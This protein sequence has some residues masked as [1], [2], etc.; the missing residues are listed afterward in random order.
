MQNLHAQGARI[1]GRLINKGTWKDRQIEYVDG[2][3][4]IKLKP[5]VQA[6]ALRAELSSLGASLAKDFDK[7]GWGLV[8]LS[9]G[10]DVFSAI[11]SLQKSALIGAVEPD[12][13]GHAGWTP[14]DPNFSP[15]QWALLNTGYYPLSRAGADIHVTQ[16]WDIT[17]GS[18]SVTIG[19]LD[20]G[21]PII[22][23]QLCHPD[24]SNSSRITVG[25]DYTDDS[26]A[27]DQNGHGTHVAGIAAAETNNSTG[28]AGVAGECNVLAVKV[29]DYTA[30]IRSSWVRSGVISAVDASSGSL[31]NP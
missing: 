16:A 22:N 11:D 23:G 20:T 31:V 4:A 17:R 18:S 27:G 10:S 13:V 24:L 14:N 21:I 19:I 3:V 12:Q 8:E 26:L 5:G 15:I 29:L 28:I 25:P 30:A 9:G 2:L 6:Q 1:G 7:L